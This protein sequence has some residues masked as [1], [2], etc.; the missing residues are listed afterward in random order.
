MVFQ[1]SSKSSM[2]ESLSTSQCGRE[3]LKIGS[4]ALNI[5]YQRV[6]KQNLSEPKDNVLRE[7]FTDDHF[8]GKNGHNSNYVPQILFHEIPGELRD[9]AIFLEY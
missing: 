8:T 7:S 4:G 6:S 5:N 9:I 2:W 1:N 3:K